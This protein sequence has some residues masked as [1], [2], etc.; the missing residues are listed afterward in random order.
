LLLLFVVVGVDDTANIAVLVDWFDAAVNRSCRQWC[1]AG[2][3]FDND[4][5]NDVT[6]EKEEEIR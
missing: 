5:A 2:C 1:C 6:Q 4:N 3:A